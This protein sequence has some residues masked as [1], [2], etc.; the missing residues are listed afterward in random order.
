M[1]KAVS[2]NGIEK[3]NLSGSPLYGIRKV[4]T[5]AQTLAVEDSGA[6]CLWN[7]AA[8]YTFTLPTAVKGVWYEFVVHTT[9]TSSAAKVIT[10]SASEFIVGTYEQATDGTYTVAARAADGTTIRA[11]S[12]NGSTTGGIVND[13]FTLTAISSTQ[14]FIQGRG[15]ATGSEATPFATS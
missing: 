4:L 7:T 8:G 5:G 14:W 12:G 11:W 2:L 10:A 3:L 6:L 15:N 13:R 9:I 1:A